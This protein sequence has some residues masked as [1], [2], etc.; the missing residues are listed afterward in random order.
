MYRVT[1]SQTTLRTHS[2][3][4]SWASFDFI[5]FLSTLAAVGFGVL[6]VY[7]ASQGIGTNDLSWGNI[8]VRQ[9][10]YAG[11]GLI[12]M[13]LATRVEYHLL[14]SFTWPLY[15]G[16]VALLGVLFI[17]ALAKPE[18]GIATLGAVRW[19]QV[20]P[21]QVQLSEIVNPVL[22][23]A[24]AKLL[25]E[26]ERRLRRPQYYLASIVLMGLPAG[27]VY[28]QPDL[29]TALTCVAIWLAMVVAAR[30]PW[31]YLLATGVLA[32]PAVW[33]ALNTDYIL[34]EYQR[35]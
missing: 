26:G 9:A 12:L 20:G 19:I 28:I 21:I 1:V 35:E 32:A 34:K 7:S 25:C 5:L 22:V 17:A 18:L 15:L 33:L 23:L 30:I 6:M 10:I 31:R 8:A 11:V 24:L 27:L 16:A 4:R 13:L 3:V 2:L 29:G 14:E